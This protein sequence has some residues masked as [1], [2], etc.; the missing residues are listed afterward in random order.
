MAAEKRVLLDVQDLKVYYKVKRHTGKGLKS[1]FA[2][3]KLSVKAVDGISFKV[4]ERE[5]FGLVGESG[6]GKSTTGR[7]IIRLNTPTEGKILF[8][9]Q[10]LFGDN[11]RR[12]RMELAKKIQIIFQD[13]FSS[14]DPRFTVGH[15]ID[16]PL[17]IHGE[18]DRKSRRERV[19]KLMN[20]VG[21]REEQYTKYPHEFSGGQRQR[22]SVAR[23]LALNPKLIICD[24]P[25]SALD[26]SIQAQVL[27]LMQDLQEEY[28]LTYIFISHNL[29][30]VKH[31]CDRIAVMYLGH[32]VEMADKDELF[33]KPEHP[34]TQA[35][36][37]AIPVPDPDVRTMQEMLEGDV[38]SPI[39]PP[40]GCCFCTRCPKATDL[41]RKQRPEAKDIGNDHIVACHYL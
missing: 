10:E 21:L 3:Q 39:N 28:A 12:R 22:I 8:E 33:R 1:L 30:V 14:L 31:F 41:C 16:E 34:Y 38:P 4:Y 25:V 27:N 17:I 9:G 7:T 37:D 29:S 18:G 6:C 11:S 36:M 26:V 35:L 23:A 24:E 40:S 19:L 5:S 20:D 15:L 2:T 13:P 32:I